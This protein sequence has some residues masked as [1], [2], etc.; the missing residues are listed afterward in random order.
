MCTGQDRTGSAE[1]FAMFSQ[2]IGGSSWYSRRCLVGPELPEDLRGEEMCE[3]VNKNNYSLQ[4][5]MSQILT[6]YT[7]RV[8]RCWREVDFSFGK[9]ISWPL[10]NWPRWLPRNACFGDT[11]YFKWLSETLWMKICHLF[12]EES[13]NLSLMLGRRF[14][15]YVSGPFHVGVNTVSG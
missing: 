10:E 8:K 13:K 7:C 1:D 15:T 6:L 14:H 12:D 5:A 9:Q 11:L 4:F 2:H 3:W